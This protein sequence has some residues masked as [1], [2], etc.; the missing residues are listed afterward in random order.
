M[1]DVVQSIFD[2]YAELI[3]T[4]HLRPGA[5]MPTIG[6]DARTWECT[7]SRVYA[8]RQQLQ[9][10]GLI[11]RRNFARPGY[12]LNDIVKGVAK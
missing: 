12:N 1:T 2:Y 3:R 10:A 8:A 5:E 11:K 9:D 4:G 7:L 6:D